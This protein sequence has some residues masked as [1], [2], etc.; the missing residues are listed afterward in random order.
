MWLTDHQMNVLAGLEFGEVISRIPLVKS[1][2]IRKGNAPEIDWAEFV[3]PQRLNYIVGN[4]PFIG[5][6]NQF[7][8]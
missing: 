5:K 7:A 6:S 4:P 8:A 3:P 1:A 2:N